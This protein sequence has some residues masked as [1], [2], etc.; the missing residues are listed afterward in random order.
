MQKKVGVGAMF[1]HSEV[2]PD[3]NLWT[4]ESGFDG[5]YVFR[6]GGEGSTYANSTQALSTT[7]NSDYFID[8]PYYFW[9]Y[10]TSYGG[11]VYAGPVLVN[12][13]RDVSLSR[14]IQ[15]Y[16]NGQWNYFYMTTKGYSNVKAYFKQSTGEVFAWRNNVLVAY[17]SGISSFHGDELYGWPTQI[18][19]NNLRTGMGHAK[20]YHNVKD[21][22]VTNT[23]GLSL[24]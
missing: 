7:P 18:R 5:T 8:L 19:V 11:H 2:L 13:N 10:G 16:Y 24:S 9:D 12:H 15:L 20:M 1:L 22:D 4:G 21:S 14:R 23:F 3:P 17:D 6:Y